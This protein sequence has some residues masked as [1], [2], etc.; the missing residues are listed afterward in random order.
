MIDGNDTCKGG[1]LGRLFVDVKWERIVFSRKLYDLFA[2][3]VVRPKFKHVPRIVVF[4]GQPLTPS[5]QSAF[6]GRLS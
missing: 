6:S 5:R 1:L 2:R 3:D 4:R